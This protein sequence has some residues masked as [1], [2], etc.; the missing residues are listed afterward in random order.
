MA[1]IICPECGKEYS[2]RADACP[3]CACPAPHVGST[4]VSGN[5]ISPQKTNTKHSIIP[6]IILIVLLAVG[7]WYAYR[8]WSYHDGLNAMYSGNYSTAR[9]RLEGLDYNDSNWVLND[10]S[11]LEDMEA[12]V[13]EEISRDYDGIDFTEEEASQTLKEI[14]RYQ[15]LEF[16][17]DGLDSIVNQYAEGLERIVN[18]YDYDSANAVQFELLAG[19]YY[20][21][22]VIVTLHENLGFMQNSTVYD[23]TYA[24]ILSNEEA[25][26][27]ALSDLAER[28]HVEMK[29]GDFRNSTIKLYLRNDTDYKYEQVYIFEFCR[30]KSDE[31]LDS[32][33]TD[34]LEIEPHSEYTVSIDVPQSA[35][36]GY[37]IHYSYYILNVEVSG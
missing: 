37:S 35:R 3:N 6:S 36:S 22:Q 29:D 34:T 1:L 12:I 23:R 33:T 9:K 17:T 18:A 13:R 21:D 2:D 14:R 7:A 10:I 20:C 19:K 24:D 15:A 11:F 27:T 26:L 25:Y 30:Y 32:V 16:H 4:E 28:G 31:L 5:A 8:I